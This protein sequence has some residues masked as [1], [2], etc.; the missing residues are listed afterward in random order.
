MIDLGLYIPWNYQE[1]PV[2]YRGFASRVEDDILIT[3]HG[4]E[5]LS[6]TC[7]KEIDDLYSILDQRSLST[8]SSP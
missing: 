2:E 1:I 3:D 4:C 7:P 8:R 5:V 6:Q